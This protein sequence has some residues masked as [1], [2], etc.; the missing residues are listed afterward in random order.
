LFRNYLKAAIKILPAPIFGCNII[1]LSRGKKIS[2]EV[3]PGESE[4]PI[5]CNGRY[6]TKIKSIKKSRVYNG[7]I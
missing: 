2:L 6:E 4:K 1:R 5:A 3:F 7:P